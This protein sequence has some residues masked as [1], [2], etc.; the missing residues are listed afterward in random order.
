MMPLEELDLRRGFGHYPTGVSVVSFEEEGRPW[1]LTASSFVSV[2][3]RPPLVMIAVGKAARSHDRLRGHPFTVN[4]LRSG[5][6]DVAR[7]FA[8]GDDDARLGTEFAWSP[9]GPHLPDVLAYFGCVPWDRVDA[10]DHTMVL[11]QVVLAHSRDGD[12]LG[13]FR[14]RFVA[15][16]QPPASQPIAA[17]DPTD[18][19][20]LPYDAV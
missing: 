12:A 7:R 8:G 6:E 4:V 11:G 16:S 15:V 1:G 18:P 20:E 9:V 2:S 14:S 13:F 5:Q 10:G 19:Y 3:L 17:F